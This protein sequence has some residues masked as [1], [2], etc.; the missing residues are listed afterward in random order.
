MEWRRKKNRKNK[1]RI[2]ERRKETE[3]RGME[4]KNQQEQKS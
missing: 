3:E 4:W 2:E 1:K